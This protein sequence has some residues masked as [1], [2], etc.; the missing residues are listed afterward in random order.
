MES[1][2]Q[3][4]ERGDDVK[5]RLSAWLIDRLEY[6]ANHKRNNYSEKWQTYDRMVKGAYKNQYDDDNINEN[7][8]SQAY[9]NICEQKRKSAIAQIDDAITT[10]NR[11]P[12]A[13]AETPESESGDDVN[14]ALTSMGVDMKKALSAM[15]RKIQDNLD[16]SKSMIELRRTVDDCSKYGVGCFKSPNLYMDKARIID[17]T[18]LQSAPAI[19]NENGKIT[20]NGEKT[21]D[22][23]LK[24]QV[25]PNLKL[26]DKE[27]IGLKRIRPADIF[28]DP[29]CEGDAQKGFGIFERNHYSTA[30]LRKMADEMIVLDG[31]KI[32]KYSK[33][34]ILNILKK[35]HSD[36]SEG[37]NNTDYNGS[38]STVRHDTESDFLNFRGIPVYT[39]YGD[40]LKIDIQ[41]SVSRPSQVED[42]EGELS[43]Y[44]T[45]SVI[46]DFTR[47]GEILRV[48]ENPHPSGLRPIHI[49]QWDRIDGEWVGKGICEKLKDLQEE[50]NRFLTYWIDN[51][52]LSSSVILAVITAKLDRT[53]NEDMR[54]Y[55]GKTFFLREGDDIRNMIQQFKIEDV[56]GPFLEGL[57]RL[58]EL[59]DHESGVPRIIEGQGSADAKTAFETQQQEAHALKQLGMVIKNL[60]EN[61]VIGLEMIY[62]YLL[63][64]GDGK[65]AVIGDF[66]VVA[67]GYSSFESKRI[68]LVELDRLIQLSGLPNV[69]PHVN[70]RRI[71]E[72]KL[73]ILGIE[74]D[75]YLN[76]IAEVQA[77]QQQQMQMAQQ[78]QQIAVQSAIQQKQAEIQANAQAKIAVD[79][80]NNQAKM[81]MEDMKSKFNAYMAQ[82][83]AQFAAS[84][85]ERN[86]DHDIKRDLMKYEMQESSENKQIEASK[87]AQEEK[88][89]PMEDKDD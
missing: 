85:A 29:S 37:R 11:F 43:D 18:V 33:E 12:F 89:E 26:S 79:Q 41:G 74:K 24:S 28:P 69:A 23:W 81:G 52:L 56:S 58:M 72:D 63:V 5:G 62:Q 42:S 9:Y 22:E 35:H 80:Q 31:E 87:E 1:E 64:Y 59:I 84:E 32:Q 39:F 82:M 47:E 76:P 73:D 38:L 25:I 4:Q 71:I 3:I 46:V 17:L 6:C 54:M 14:K 19:E 7:W 75:A 67:R 45:V 53:E 66:K 60:D 49:W 15:E 40:V 20:P 83:E 61:I 21:R 65:G 48:I 30:T 10:G 8:R 68:K 34:A 88:A 13:L 70:I 77:T 44:D 36:V 2:I 51:K 78:Q 86:R 27:R 50:F 16:E 55:P 57:F